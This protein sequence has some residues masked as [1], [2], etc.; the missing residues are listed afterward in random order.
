MSSTTECDICCETFNKSTLKRVSCSSCPASICR[1][2]TRKYLIDSNDE[3]HCMS[4]KNRWERDVFIQACLKTFVDNDWR[5]HHGDVLVEDEMSRM[6]STMPAVDNY[7]V[8]KQL[9]KNDNEIKNRV[10]ELKNEMNVLRSMQDEIY[11]ELRVRQDSGGFAGKDKRVFIK[12]CPGNKCKGFLSSKYKCEICDLKVCA[13]CFA[14]KDAVGEETKQDAHVC[15]EDDILSAELIKKETRHCPNCATDIFKT[16]GC[17]Q[18]WCTQC[19]TPFSWKTGLKVKGTVHNPHFYAWQAAGGVAAVAPGAVLCGG[20]PPLYNFRVGLIRAMK[21]LY[22]NINPRRLQDT[23]EGE[24]CAEAIALHRAT[25]HFEGVELDRVRLLCNE[26][27]NHEDLRIR[28]IL[29]LISSEEM[30]ATILKRYKQKE[31]AQAILGIYELVNTVF[32]DSVRDIYQGI[33]RDAQQSNDGG[34][35]E[36]APGQ[37]PYNIITRNLERCHS[38]RAYANQNLGKVSVIYSQYV[39]IIHQDFYT[40]N[41]KFKRKDLVVD[42]AGE[43]GFV[44][45]TLSEPEPTTFPPPPSGLPTSSAEAI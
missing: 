7:K 4:C 10:Q 24:V 5:S 8:C 2:C 27:I 14:I 43:T 42:S 38:I 11:I 35:I 9:K 23:E 36:W 34:C 20:L 13:K 37:N 28:Y 39:G 41:K 45:G 29:G 25:A 44:G 31:K 18:M 17:D 30:K 16:E 19:Q 33:V 1:L 21:Q 12:K 3:P 22:P 15:N 32:T 40:L 26:A 6:S